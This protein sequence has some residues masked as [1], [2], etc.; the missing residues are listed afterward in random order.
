MAASPHLLLAGLRY[1]YPTFAFVYFF[2]YSAITTCTFQKPDSKIE[3][4]RRRLIKF[5]ML[6]VAGTFSAQCI[7]ALTHWHTLKQDVLVSLLACAMV[8]GLQFVILHDTKHP[9]WYSYVGSWAIALVFDPILAVLSLRHRDQR[10]PMSARAVDTL[11]LATR[12]TFLVIAVVVF[13]IWQRE[14]FAEAGSDTERQSLLRKDRDSEDTLITEYGSTDSEDGPGKSTSDPE[15]DFERSQRLLEENRDKRLQESGNWLAY[16]K[17]FKLFFP[18]VWP[19]NDRRLQVYAG[20]VGLCL[21]ANNA[22]NV[23]IPNQLGVVLRTLQ[24]A[25]KDEDTSS[26]WNPWIQ[27]II[28][29]FLKLSASTAGISMLRQR[30][31]LPVEQYAERA[32]VEAAHS[33]ILNLDAQFHDT[34]SLSDMLMAIQNGEAIS[35][36][37]ETICFE[38]VPNLIDLGVAF[39][40][41]TVKFGPWEGLITISTSTIFIYLATHALARS[42]TGLQ[43]FSKAWYEEWYIMN[44]GFTGW[45][46]VASFNQ[47]PHESSRFSKAV[48][49]RI[50]KSRSYTLEYLSAQAVQYLVLSAGLLAGLLLAVWQVTRAHS[51]DASDFVVL[52]TYWGQLVTP[53][54][55]FAQLGKQVNRKLIDAERLVEI[56][57]T[58]P[59]VTSKPNAPSFH[60]EAGRVEFQDVQFSYDKKKEI[61][62]N[63]SF[64]VKP[65]ETIA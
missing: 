38:M 24:D 32:M 53:L 13:F 56:M 57:E 52:L 12:V 5:L 21:L 26:S 64:T 50:A 29:A 31:W 63:L 44:S 41:L 7:L 48:R 34:K 33:H 20:L 27:V 35:S 65:G 42:R 55:F 47:V 23:L 8:Y 30:L 22:F 49:D 46:T 36:L 25:S 3:H 18:Y 16:A 15:S 17:S 28:F 54:N 40:Y 2:L 4:P 39:I 45:T 61:L 58:K 51:I 43:A 9:I 59:K 10:L 14:S 11:C 6:A 1:A 19:V 37:L 62:K 60:F